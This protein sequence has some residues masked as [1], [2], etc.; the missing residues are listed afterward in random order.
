MHI[1]LANLFMR[2]EVLPTPNV[3]D[4]MLWIDRVI[5]HSKRNLRI[6]LKRK[7]IKAA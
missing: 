7:D 4:D 1:V 2:Y 3:H 5:V 6:R